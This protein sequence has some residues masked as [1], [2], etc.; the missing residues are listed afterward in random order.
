MLTIVVRITVFE[1]LLPD[2]IITRNCIVFELQTPHQFAV[3]RDA[4][5]AVLSACSGGIMEKQDG[6]PW[7]ISSYP[8]YKSRFCR[9]Y[10]DHKLELASY[11]T[12]YDKTRRA[13]LSRDTVIRPHSMSKYRVLKNGTWALNPF[14]SNSE[15]APRYLRGVCAMEV[16][17][18]GPYKT[19]PS[20]S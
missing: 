4:T 11:R 15:A 17:P 6:V 3:W 8:S 7:L 5:H 18:D 2:D 1:H 14:S 9:P 20:S 12:K 19:P 16:T 10:E 13:P